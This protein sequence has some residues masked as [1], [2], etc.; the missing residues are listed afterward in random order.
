MLYQ[1][2]EMQDALVQPFTRWSRKTS[3]LFSDPASPLASMPFAHELVAACDLVYRLGKHYDKP[4]FNLTS[5]LFKG[6]EVQIAEETVATRPFCR[7][8]HFARQGPGADHVCPTVLLVAPLSGH[9]ATLLRDTVR[10]LLHDHDVYVTEW[11]DA[12]QVPLADGPFGLND[13]IYYVQ[14]F[15]RLLGP[16]THVVAVC[17]PTVPVLAALALMASAGETGARSM[18]LLGGPIDGRV[19]PTKVNQLASDKPL[20]WFRDNLIDEVPAHYPGAGRKVYPG[21]LQ[22]AAFIAM[23]PDK[24]MQS[25]N[26]YFHQR[27]E[28]K[29]VSN[30]ERFYDEYNAVLDMSAEFYLDTIGVVFKDFELARGVWE[31]DGVPVRPQDIRATALLTVE[32][33]QDDICGVGQTFASHALC[34]AIPEADKRHLNV[35]GTGHFGIFSGH[36]WLQEVCPAITDFIAQHDH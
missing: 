9:F 16:Q 7:L 15:L 12:R 3:Q 26:D 1:L 25:Y 2:H 36:R 10:G 33:A 35:E 5:T 14:D 29:P 23:H 11:T 27:A 32:G 30:H 4:R 6:S 13:Y 28:G 20:S 34:S 18:T 17:Q 8:T 22:Y 31:V 24:H 21:F 19:S